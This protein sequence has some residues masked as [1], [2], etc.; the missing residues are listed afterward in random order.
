MALDS[1]NVRVAVTGAVYVAPTTAPAPSYSDDALD[2]AFQDLGYVSAD[3]IAETIDK[4][5]T[6]IR[7]WQDGS[8][9]R[10]I[11]SEGTYSV[12]LT[13]IETNQDVVEL[14]YGATLTNG[15]LDGD[16]RQTGGRKSFVIDVIDGNSIERTYI[17][18]GEITSVGERTLASGEAIGYQVTITAYADASSVTFKKFF[19]D[20]GSSES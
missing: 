1:D 10:E 6:Q 16:P 17:P 12:E 18:A 11:V 9:V 20:F 19:S 3:G 2:N 8:L 5:T 4:S 14:Y 7:S 15:E 13:F